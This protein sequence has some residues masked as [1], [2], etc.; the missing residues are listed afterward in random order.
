VG[1]Q[2][3]HDDDGL[4]HATAPAAVLLGQVDAKQTRGAE[5]LPQLFNVFAGAAAFQEVL[6]PVTPDDARDALPNSLV[7]HR[8][9]DES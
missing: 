3:L 7:F 8:V 5:V 4:G 9:F 6:G 2:F 1:C